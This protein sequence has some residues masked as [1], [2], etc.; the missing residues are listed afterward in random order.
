[1]LKHYHSG[2]YL[3]HVANQTKSNISS[4]VVDGYQIN[5]FI[6]EENLA[7]LSIQ[8]LTLGLMALT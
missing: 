5:F 8:A 2:D 3:E 1:M 6:K 7:T 4:F